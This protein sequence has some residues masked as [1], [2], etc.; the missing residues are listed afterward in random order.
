VPGGTCSAPLKW[1]E[2]NAKLDPK[3]YTLKTLPARMK[4]LKTDPLAAVLT[5][6]PDIH[7]ALERLM[8]RLRA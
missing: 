8:E 3:D 6:K 1:S 7:G 5:E 2:V 4:R